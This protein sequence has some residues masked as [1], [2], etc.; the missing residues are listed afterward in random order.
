MKDILSHLVSIPTVSV[1]LEANRQAIEYIDLFL[2]ERGLYVKRFDFGG[3]AALFATTQRTKTPR[4]LLAAH[5]DVVPGPARLFKLQEKGDR[6]YGRG[7]LDMKFAIAAYLQL[8]DDLQDDLHKYDFGLMI[9]TDEELGGR[10]G[11][12]ALTELGYLPEA[13]VLPDG[14]KDW[15]LEQAAKGMVWVVATATGKPGHGS[16]PWD[17][18]SANEKMMLFL[19][20][21]QRELFATQSPDTST[22]NIGTLHGG[23]AANQVADLCT[24]DIDIRPVNHEDHT[25]IVA[26]LKELADEYDVNCE[27]LINDSPIEVD[28]TDPYVIA[29]ANSLEKVTGIPLRT[30]R[31]NG[32]SDARHLAVHSIPTL[33]GY[34]V[35]G[36]S[37]SDDEWLETKS[38]YQFRDVVQDFLEQTAQVSGPSVAKS[39]TLPG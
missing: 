10:D 34:P 19:Q 23:S 13:C 21:V 16:R 26:R 29:Y 39:L 1:D 7:V 5:V 33:V 4:V 35:G 11:V 6:L 9:T 15:V 36:G 18:E 38:L 24:S 20:A 12:K 14:G 22:I 30:M 31:S 8:V 32:G 28:L 3:H 25:R 37:H 27:Y 2:S 17:G